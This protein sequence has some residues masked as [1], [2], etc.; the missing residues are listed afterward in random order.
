M[1]KYL[2]STFALTMLFLVNNSVAQNITQNETVITFAVGSFQVSTLSEGVNSGSPNMLSGTTEEMLNKYLPTG[3][4]PLEIN[5]FLV[6]T[7]DKN[8][9]IDTG[10]GV[11][12]FENL[13]LLE[14]PEDKIDVILLTHLHGDHIGG[15]MKDGKAAF[16]NAELYVA[17]AEYDYWMSKED[18]AQIRTIFDSYKS[19]LHLFEPEELGSEKPNIFEGFQGIKAYGHTPGHTAFMLESEGEKLLIWGDITHATEIQ[20]PHPEVTL[21]FD[22]NQDQARETRMKVLEYVAKNRIRIGGMHILFP[23][24]G[25][26]RKGTGDEGAYVFLPI[27]IC[28]S[29]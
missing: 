15:M 21:A 26:I 2:L 12:L 19:K 3:S 25:N 13:R 11:K 20:M 22:T 23:S 9:L 18:N 14:V 7:E 8:I 27:C 5:A 29:I 16:P 4:F 1:K 10:N 28:E 17:K 6:K 24:I